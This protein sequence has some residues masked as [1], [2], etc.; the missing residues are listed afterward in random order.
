MASS[1]GTV[2][3]YPAGQGHFALGS[4]DGQMLH[5][6]QQIEVVLADI[7]ITG[8]VRKSDLG[9]YLQLANGERCGLCACMRVRVVATML[10]A[11]GVR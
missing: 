7:Q 1:V 9:D 6:G 5:P 11:E 2:P 3:I 4:P 8:T 10:E